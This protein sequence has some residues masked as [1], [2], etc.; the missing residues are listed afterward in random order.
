MEWGSSMDGIKEG[1]GIKAGHGCGGGGDC[2]WEREVWE[3]RWM[4]CG[5]P[6]GW[7]DKG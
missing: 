7:E 4:V 1:D 3:L 6:G 5:G 2:E